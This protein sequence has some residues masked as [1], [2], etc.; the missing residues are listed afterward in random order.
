MSCHWASRLR[1]R[2]LRVRLL[3]WL[4]EMAEEMWK[5]RLARVLKLRVLLGD[6]SDAL[7]GNGNLLDRMYDYIVG[8]YSHVVVVAEHPQLA[9]T[10]RK[11]ADVAGQFKRR[12][13]VYQ[14]SVFC[15]HVFCTHA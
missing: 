2:C 12:N 15:I 9:I 8:G 1:Q 6:E 7:L 3:G 10:T 14:E 13:F 5:L 11:T 4:V